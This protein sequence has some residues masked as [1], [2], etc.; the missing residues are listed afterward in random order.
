MCIGSVHT[1]VLEIRGGRA[2]VIHFHSRVE[3]LRV[4]TDPIRAI[5]EAKQAWLCKI[6]FHMGSSEGVAEI[7]KIQATNYYKTFCKMLP[8]GKM[9]AKNIHIY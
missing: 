2:S 6:N 8:K 7:N 3:K 5:V 9:Q 4:Y 1:S